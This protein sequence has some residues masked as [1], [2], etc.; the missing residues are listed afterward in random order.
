MYNLKAV[1]VHLLTRLMALSNEELIRETFNKA[2]EA[3]RNPSML[4][5]AK[6]YLEHLLWRAKG[7]TFL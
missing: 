2:Y 4:E 7:S 6:E 1:P 5:E 3:G